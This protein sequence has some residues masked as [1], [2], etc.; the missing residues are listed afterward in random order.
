MDLPEAR[1]THA[2]G[3]SVAFPRFHQKDLEPAASIFTWLNV[4]YIS[5]PQNAGGY[6]GSTTLGVIG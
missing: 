1:K 5:H 2:V 4:K 3:A 6:N